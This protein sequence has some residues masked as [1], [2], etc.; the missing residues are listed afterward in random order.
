MDE[1][2][3]D[4]IAYLNENNFCVLATSDNNIPHATPIHY[5]NIGL[6]IVILTSSGIKLKTIPKNNR[7]SLA[8]S[9]PTPENN[10]SDITRGVQIEGSARV[11]PYGS[12]GIESLVKDSGLLRFLN[13]I[14]ISKIADSATVIKVTPDRIKFIDLTRK[15]AKEMAR[16]WI[17]EQ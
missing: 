12:E 11:I 10:G 9:S 7:V 6:D 2:E 14:G 5:G 8:V 4:I 3:K 1:L 13:S 17:R 16:W 15:N